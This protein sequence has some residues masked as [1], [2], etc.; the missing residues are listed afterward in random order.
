MAIS[1]ED[2]FSGSYSVLLAGETISCIIPTWG[3]HM[4]DNENYIIFNTVSDSL[5]SA[6]IGNSVSFG[7]YKM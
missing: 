2:D 3:K 6:V 4:F 7:N 1:Q 5:R